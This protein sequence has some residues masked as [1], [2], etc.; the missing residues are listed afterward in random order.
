LGPQQ[1]AATAVSL[2]VL[3]LSAQELVLNRQ[4]L[5]DAGCGVACG[6]CRPWVGRL[7]AARFLECQLGDAGAVEIARLLLGDARH[8]A[9]PALS[10]AA[11]NLR[12]L[13]LSANRIGDAGIARIAEALPR[14]DALER[15]LVDRNCIGPAGAMSLGKCLPRSNLREL[16]LGS[17]LGGN[18]VG[19]VGAT[20]LARAL[21]DRMERAAADRPN[22]LQALNLEDCMVGA[23]GAKALAGH[24]PSS[25]VKALS[26]AR[27]Q[28]GDDG[29][30]MV[31]AALPACAVS[32]DLAG[33]GLGDETGILAGQRLS[34]MPSLGV[35][36]AQND[37][38]MHLKDVLREEHG[39]RCRV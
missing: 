7:V 13:V 18:P 22:R 26:V 21:D 11:C 6:F 24:L 32:L 1:T 27:G 28:L 14:C 35:S 34:Q 36:L 15:L 12:E 25:D 38:S 2:G 31:L 4:P 29:A 30:A 19:P 17:H 16:V 39:A 9:S 20:A 33:N 5:G 37:L 10:A 3:R 8:R 23:A